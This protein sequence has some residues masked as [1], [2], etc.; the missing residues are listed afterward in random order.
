VLDPVEFP[1]LG[2][3]D[4]DEPGGLRWIQL[5]ELAAATLSAGGCIGFSIAIYDPDQDADGT[6]AA[7]IVEFVGHVIRRAIPRG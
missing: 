2:L 3:P 5:T 1:A 7:H 4:A 6:D